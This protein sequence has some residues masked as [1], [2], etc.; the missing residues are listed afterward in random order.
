MPALAV[1]DELRRRGA[2]VEFIGGERAEVELVAGAGFP[3][4]RLRVA[5]L[6]RR[7]PV[8]AAR[9]LA[10]AGRATSRARGILRGMGA[11]AVL[12]AGGYVA[13]P[14]GLAARSLGL[15]LALTEADSH[16]G[17][18]NRLLAPLARRVFLAFPIAG[19]TGGRYVVSGRPLAADTGR[20]DR[21]VA[22]ERFGLPADSPCVL[23]FGGSLGA[24]RLNR[25]AVEAFGGPGAP[26]AVLHACGHRD[27]AELR[28]RLDE[29]GS[30]AHYRLFAYVEPFADALAAADLVVSRAGGSVLEVAAAGLPAILVPYP[31]ASADH[32]TA[33]ARF[34]ERAGAAVVVPDGD[35]DAARLT[36]EV[37]ALLAAPERLEAMS[38]AARAAGRPGAAGMIADEL[39]ALAAQH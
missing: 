13:G 20:A 27:H 19:C 21:T 5:G 2:R 29:L 31:Q 30:P 3:L 36:R 11:G 34:M 7:N 12:G 1:A 6:D 16:L 25:A 10:L 24:R 28:G 32:Q 4:H 17:I 23:I 22:R 26:I 33:N 39:L 15:P 35:L 9:A 18:S 37:E 8:R 14:A 38:E